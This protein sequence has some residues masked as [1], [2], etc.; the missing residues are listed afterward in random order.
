ME[1]NP[2]DYH[3]DWILKRSFAAHSKSAL[4]IKSE[5]LKKLDEERVA[6]RAKDRERDETFAISRPVEVIALQGPA[7]QEV[8]ATEVAMWEDFDMGDAVFDAGEDPANVRSVQ[9]KEFERRAQQYG[10]W[11][12]MDTNRNNSERLWDESEQ[13][14]VISEILK[15][16]GELFIIIYFPPQC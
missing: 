3:G 16:I 11:H 13:E 10:L 6:A 15:N 1:F 9:H 2:L 7:Q 5:A 8:N 12:G 14:D 4:H